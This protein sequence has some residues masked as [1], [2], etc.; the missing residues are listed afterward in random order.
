M[1]ALLISDIHAN[2]DALETVLDTAPAHDVVWNLGDVVGY[3]AA[4]NEDIERVRCLGNTFVPGNHDRSCSGQ[5][6]LE[7]FNPVASRAARWTRQVLTPEHV[8]W[9]QNMAPGA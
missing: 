7:D 2:I 6:S 9:L 5:L 1:R 4:P 8:D 3:G